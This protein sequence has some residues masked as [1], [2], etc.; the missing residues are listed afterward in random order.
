MTFEDYNYQ[1]HNPYILVN[2]D[3]IH[4]TASPNPLPISAG[5]KQKLEKM[6]NFDDEN[7]KPCMNKTLTKKM[8]NESQRSMDTYKYDDMNIESESQAAER[9][10]E[11]RR[12]R[13][14]RQN[15][16]RQRR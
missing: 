15:S 2:K 4:E 9:E 8:M 12:E 14:I 3:N 11:V 1:S 7:D 13:E 10:Q 16:S 6:V 5:M